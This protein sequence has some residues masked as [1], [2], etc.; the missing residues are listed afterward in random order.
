M[1]AVQ[2]SVPASLPYLL[3]LPHTERHHPPRNNTAPADPSA[4]GPIAAQL[5]KGHDGCY[6]VSRHVRLGAVVE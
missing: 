3:L 5:Q 4:D 6:P 1:V 2:I